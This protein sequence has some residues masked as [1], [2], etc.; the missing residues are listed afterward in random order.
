MPPI[1]FSCA[2]T[3]YCACSGVRARAAREARRR[4]AHIAD[5]LAHNTRL[6][7]FFAEVVCTLGATPTKA[8]R[9][10]P[11]NGDLRCERCT[12]ELGPRRG[13]HQTGGNCTNRGAT[14]RRHADTVLL[15]V[16][17]PLHYPW[18]ML[19]RWCRTA[20]PGPVGRRGRCRR[21]VSR[22]TLESL[23]GAG[24]T[25]LVVADREVP[26]A[27]NLGEPRWCGAWSASSATTLVADEAIHLIGKIQPLL[28]GW[29]LPDQVESYRSSVIPRWAHP[30]GGAAARARLPDDAPSTMPG[31]EP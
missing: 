4:C 28:I 20:R 16:Q 22:R 13:R 12:V 30:V 29:N 14:R 31:T 2:L 6:S 9:G 27:T 1:G 8:T 19:H 15:M 26:V 3:G 25:D 23:A 5:H 17:N 24:V 7:A 10:P 11:P 21:L 18:C